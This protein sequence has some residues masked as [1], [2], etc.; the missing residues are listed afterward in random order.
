L[1][2]RF[3]AVWLIFRLQSLA[4]RNAAQGT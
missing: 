3:S 4:D 1:V 2:G